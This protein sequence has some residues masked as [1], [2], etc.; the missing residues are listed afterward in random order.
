M[1]VLT[2]C[3]RATKKK[4]QKLNLFC[5]N[6]VA[7]MNKRLNKIGILKEWQ[8]NRLFVDT[9]CYQHGGML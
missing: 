7:K 4:Q 2:S 8:I 1:C 3:N 9:H 5:Y 6:A